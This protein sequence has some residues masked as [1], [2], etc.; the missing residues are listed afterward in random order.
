MIS[1]FYY[2][3]LPDQVAI[4]FDHAGNP[5][6]Y[7]PKFLAAFGIPALMLVVYIFMVSK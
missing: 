2:N 4:H 5:D 3:K 7:E 1:A 6:N